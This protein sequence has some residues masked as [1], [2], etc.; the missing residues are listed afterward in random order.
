MIKIEPHF[1]GAY[2][3]SEAAFSIVDNMPATDFVDELRALIVI[4]HA[5]MSHII[6][7]KHYGTDNIARFVSYTQEIKEEMRR[8]R[9]EKR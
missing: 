6:E 7:G 4:Q 5:L 1:L 2:L 9:E 8:I 3:A